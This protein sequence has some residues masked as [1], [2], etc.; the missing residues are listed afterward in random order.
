MFKMDPIEWTVRKKAYKAKFLTDSILQ[1]L[2]LLQL[3][4]V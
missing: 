4:S 3:I 2:F 1:G